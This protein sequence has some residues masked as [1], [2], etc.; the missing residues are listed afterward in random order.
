MSS[1]I[2]ESKHV[3]GVFYVPAGESL[4]GRTVHF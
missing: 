4:A 3:R 1:V 2:P